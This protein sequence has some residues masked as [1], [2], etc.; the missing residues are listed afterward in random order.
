MNVGGFARIALGSDGRQKD[1][2]TNQAAEY[3]KDRHFVLIS[4]K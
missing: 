3:C 4:S 1:G 2:A